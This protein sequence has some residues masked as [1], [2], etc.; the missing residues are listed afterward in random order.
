MEP[1][2]AVD[3]KKLSRGGFVDKWSHFCITL[4]RKRIGIRIKVKKRIRIR[5]QEIRVIRIRI[6]VTRGIPIRNTV[7]GI[8]NLVKK[9]IWRQSGAT[10][11]K[12]GNVTFCKK[13]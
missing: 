8:R 6:T 11:N 3:A 2:R 1:W 4:M 9:K 10:V 7:K 5:I 13:A 12:K